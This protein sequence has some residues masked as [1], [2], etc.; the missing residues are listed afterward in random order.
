MRNRVLAITLAGLAAAS[1]LGLSAAYAQHPGEDMTQCFF[2]HDWDGWKAT[3]DNKTIYIRVGMNRIWRLDLAYACP[4]LSIPNARLIT[5]E[6]GSASICTALDLNLKVEDA[7][8][9]PQGCNVS[10]IAPLSRD[11]AAAL[12]RSLRP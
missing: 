5:D 3:P 11:E 1:T 8:G 10:H 12:P 6:R 4:A 2:A 9:F 7:D